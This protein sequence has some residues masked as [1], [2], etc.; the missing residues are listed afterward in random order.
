MLEFSN[1]G[2]AFVFG[3]LVDDK[4]RFG[5][6]FA[7]QVL[8][9]IVFFAALM[10]LLYHVGVMPFIVRWLGGCSRARSARAAP[11]ASRR[12]PTS[13]WARPRRRW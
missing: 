11:R 2:A 10:S 1:Q 7:F 5:F 3:P 12:S 6:V 13:S 8:P 4:E 9:T